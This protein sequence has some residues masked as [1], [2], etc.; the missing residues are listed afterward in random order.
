MKHILQ[1]LIN[2]I[3][4]QEKHVIIGITGHGGAGKTTFATEL[5]QAFEQEVNMVSADP[6]IVSSEL[7]KNTMITYTFQSKVHT[8][9]M[10]ACHPLAHHV[11][12]LERDLQMTRAGLEWNTIDTSYLP[13]EIIS[14]NKKLTIVEGMSIAF[15]HPGYL[16]LQI[17]LYT[18]GETELSRRSSR[19][20]VE[21]NRELDAIQKSHQE[22][23]AQYMHFMHNFKNQAD[24][25][26]F[27]N[28][29]GM[30]IEKQQ[31]TGK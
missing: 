14:P 5:K 13:S 16:D 29:E 24:I 1:E 6:Y 25:I 30:Q 3:H 27:T 19:D 7:R 9:K 15:I 22:R 17:Y 31:L 28:E 12:A 10:T 20:T 23:R 2:W 11:E 4:A 21:R 26:L 8:A 18:D